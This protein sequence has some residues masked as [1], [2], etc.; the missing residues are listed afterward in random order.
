[1]IWLGAVLTEAELTPD[2]VKEKICDDCNLCVKSCPVNALENTEIK[3]V[4][5]WNCAFGDDK[6]KK[7][8]E[9][10]VINAGMYVR[11]I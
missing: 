8:G 6:E 9:Y 7:V 4:D 11:T 3:Q 10:P 1:M 2:E 5:C